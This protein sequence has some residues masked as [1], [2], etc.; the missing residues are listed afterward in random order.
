MRPFNFWEFWVPAILCGLVAFFLTYVVLGG[1][2]YYV[3][4]KLLFLCEAAY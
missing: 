4:C 1:L 3:V 2:F